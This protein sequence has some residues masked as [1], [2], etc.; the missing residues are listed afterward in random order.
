M[1]AAFLEGWQS[2]QTL[3]KYLKTETVK[4]GKVY[5]PG[6]IAIRRR[7]D[8]GAPS[9][10]NF[11]PESS[12]WKHPGRSRQFQ[13]LGL[14]LQGTLQLLSGCLPPAPARMRGGQFSTVP[15]GDWWARKLS[16]CRS[17]A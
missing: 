6:R 12:G 9:R 13:A 4:D 15:G 16:F 10:F 8:E 7:P 11:I 5:L 1:Q 2:V 14:D 3:H 17:G